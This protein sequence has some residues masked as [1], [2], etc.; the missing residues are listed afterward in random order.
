MKTYICAAFPVGTDPDMI[1]VGGAKREWVAMDHEL[2]KIKA[3]AALL[4][5]CQTGG[6]QI[7]TIWNGVL[8][9]DER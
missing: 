2:A 8:Y 9:H 6:V 1:S 5:E 3:I 7:W 4:V